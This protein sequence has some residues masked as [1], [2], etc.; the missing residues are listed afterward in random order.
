[1]RPLGPKQRQLFFTYRHEPGWKR[2]AGGGGKAK[3]NVELRCRREIRSL[4]DTMVW[5]VNSM[6]GALI[7]KLFWARWDG[8]MICLKEITDFSMDPDCCTS[9]DALYRCI[10][11]DKQ[12]FFFVQHS[13]TILGHISYFFL[14]SPRVFSP[15][16]IIMDR[17]WF[18]KEL[19]TWTKSLAKSGIKGSTAGR[20]SRKS[21]WITMEKRSGWH[22]AR[23]AFLN[24]AF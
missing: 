9:H 12:A 17:R 20:P 23:W 5:M 24:F 13:I 22:F 7:Q 16:K 4:Q 10:P 1:M 11:E 18:M 2:G 14:I 8:W 3:K 6:N 15:T 21:L 19:S